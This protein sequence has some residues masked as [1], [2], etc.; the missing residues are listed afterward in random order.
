MSGRI[1]PLGVDVR[2]RLGDRRAARQLGPVG[3]SK[4]GI[5]PRGQ[6]LA[7]RSR[8]HSL[9]DAAIGAGLIQ[10][11]WLDSKSAAEVADSLADALEELRRL[12]RN[13]DRRTGR[14][15]GRRERP[16]ASSLDSRST[17]RR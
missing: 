15:Q 11:D 4:R 1:D 7:S 5:G 9:L 8:K 14:D 17:P 3:V 2:P 16:S 13:L 12:K 10:A 6:I